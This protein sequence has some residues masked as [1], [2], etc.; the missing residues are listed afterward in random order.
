VF[1]TG[2][3]YRGIGIPACIRDGAAIGQRAAKNLRSLQD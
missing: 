3:A 1:V 2:A